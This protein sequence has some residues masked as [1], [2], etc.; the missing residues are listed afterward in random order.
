[1]FNA[2]NAYSDASWRLTWETKSG[3]EKYERVIANCDENGNITSYTHRDYNKVYGTLPTY[4]KAELEKTSNDFLAS[5]VP[6]VYANVKLEDS[7]GSGI[8]SGQYTY[9][10]T[11]YIDGYLY[12]DNYVNV[13]VDYNTGVVTQM[14]IDYDYKLNIAKP[15]AIITP[16]KAEEI[17]GTKQKMILTYLTKND[18]NEETKENTVK[19]FLVYKPETSYLAV[20]AGTG[21]IYDT[22]SSW[23]VN[24]SMGSGGG[25]NATLKGEAAMGPMESAKDEAG[26]E[27]TEEELAGV[28]ELEGLISKEEAIKAVTE[29]KYLYVN[30]ALTAVD[31]RLEK[32]YNA[33]PASTYRNDNGSYIWYINF[34][35]P[36]IDN[37]YYTYAYADATVNAETGEIISY[38]CSLNDYYY[39]TNNK[40]DIPEVKYNEDEARKIAEEF[41]TEFAKDKF[42]SSVETFHGEENVIKRT[43]DG[44]IEEYGAHSFRYTRVNEGIQFTRNS[45]SVGVDGVTGKIHNFGYNWWTNVEFESPKEAMSP[46]KAL[47]ALLSNE[48]YGVI[49]ERNVTYIYNPLTDS[50]KKDICVAFVASLLMTKDNGG[51]I[52]K[53]IDKYAKNIDREKL[54]TLLNTA[55]ED[56]LLAFAC[57][58]YGITEKEFN[59]ASEYIDTSLFYDKET[60]A[61]LVYTCYALPSTYVSP[62]TGKLLNSRGEELVPAAT[63][64][65]YSDLEGHWIEKDALLLADIGIGFEGGTFNPDKEITFEDFNKLSQ[66]IGYY[67]SYNEENKDKTV[68]RIDAIKSIINALG[69]EKVANLKGIYKTDFADN[70]EIKEEDIGYVSIAFGLGVIKGDGTNVNAYDTLTR[71]Q[72]VSILLNTVKNAR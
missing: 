18:Y 13:S 24:D 26:Y 62:F 6:E 10:Y 40:L 68:L 37:K 34:S 48:G 61:R 3:E 47:S 59:E 33:Q 50:S 35:N 51:D 52:D 44:K 8:Y 39:Y 36:V 28:K 32:N 11:R 31:A 43:S 65:T 49:Y 5:V 71:A 19:A 12:P 15:E 58:H 64:Y 70:G 4:S 41:L 46:E 56:G 22:K 23:S 69:Y 9:Y 38:S 57:A 30:P 60:D 16:E 42:E 17:L 55:D 45:I 21:E 27:L 7:Y 67:V 54:N 2:K 72:A 1:R 14:S 29:N 25:V 20:D 63:S 66:S 53:V